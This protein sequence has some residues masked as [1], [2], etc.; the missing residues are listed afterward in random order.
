MNYLLCDVTFIFKLGIIHKY[1]EVERGYLR[2][3]FYLPN[4]KNIVPI[5]CN[6]N[7]KHFDM[8]HM[9]GLCKSSLTSLYFSVILYLNNH[10]YNVY[11]MISIVVFHLTEGHTSLHE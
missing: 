7:I 1:N 8:Y 4:I 9:A 10:V 11:V 2:L 5:G 3:F 6:E